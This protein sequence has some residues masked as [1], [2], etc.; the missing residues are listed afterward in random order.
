MARVRVL[1]LAVLVSVPAWA[2]IKLLVP[3]S[4]QLTDNLGNPQ[5][6]GPCGGA[7]TASNAVTTVVAG[8]QLTVS[9]DETILHPGYF[10]I[11][12]AR[13]ANEF[14][15]PTPVLNQNGA[16]CASSPTQSNPT[17]PIL[18]DG[19]FQHS[20]AMPNGM[21]STQVTV[22]MMS[23]DN[24]VLQLMQFMSSHA[25]PCYYFQCATLRIVM[26]DAGSPVVDAG[27]PPGDA[28]TSPE[29]D[30]GTASDAGNTPPATD[31]GTVAD[32]G[33]EHNHDEQPTVG[34]GCTSSP[35]AV[36]LAPMLW[37]LRR[38]SR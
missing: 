28:G 33:H 3:D 4:F 37:W 18:V 25:P 34:C 35:F 32:G 27:P 24:C 7:G 17:Y 19:L 36:L 21:W 11:G 14:V 8:S 13:T 9:W 30:A 2:H 5:K 26:P 15:T 31:A 20:T 1:L 23:C 16:N 29:T 22:P 38:R 10:R 6:V 12:I